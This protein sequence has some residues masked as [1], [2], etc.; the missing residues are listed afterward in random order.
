VIENI[1]P[2]AATPPT[3]QRSRLRRRSVRSRR[4]AEFE[5]LLVTNEEFENCTVIFD[6]R[7]PMTHGRKKSAARRLPMFGQPERLMDGESLLRPVSVD[8]SA[9][10][11]Q[12]VV[13][14]WWQIQ[15]KRQ[16]P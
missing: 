11:E 13:E 12:P 3:K 1:K 15:S 9:P 8:H 10:L 6:T 16:R 4:F 14:C 5:R 2:A 7:W